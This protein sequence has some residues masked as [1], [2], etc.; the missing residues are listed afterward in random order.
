MLNK[1]VSTTYEIVMLFH[2]K[3]RGRPNDGGPDIASQNHPRNHFEMVRV[4]LF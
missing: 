4:F 1:N 2:I 3:E